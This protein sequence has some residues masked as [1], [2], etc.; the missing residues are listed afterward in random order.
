MSGYLLPTQVAGH[1]DQVGTTFCV[2]MGIVIRTLVQ[3][4]AIA[5]VYV[6]LSRIA[7]APLDGVLVFIIV[8]YHP[9]RRRCRGANRLRF[10]SRPLL[11]D[12]DYGESR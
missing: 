10:L 3:S 4:S 7:A 5:F 2:R 6:G 1:F 9:I 12:R 11:Q 8:L